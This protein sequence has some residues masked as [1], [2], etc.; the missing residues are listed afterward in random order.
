LVSNMKTMIV[1]IDSGITNWLPSAAITIPPIKKPNV[2]D[3]NW[4]MKSFTKR[5]KKSTNTS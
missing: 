1:Q 3:C 5:D 4:A 2:G